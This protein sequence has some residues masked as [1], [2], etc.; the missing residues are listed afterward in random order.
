MQLTF[1]LTENISSTEAKRDGTQ[2]S[3]A[4]LVLLEDDL[5]QEE[6]VGD[7]RH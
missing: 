1:C 6:K 2:L 5:D 4:A 7:L 3:N